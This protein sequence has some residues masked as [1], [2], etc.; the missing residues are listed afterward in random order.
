MP[1]APSSSRRSAA[2]RTTSTPTSSPARCSPSGYGPAGEPGGGRPRRREHLRVHRGGPRGVDR[3]DP[4]AG[5]A[6]A[7]GRPPRRHRLPGRALRRRAR[8]AIPEVD[9]VAGVRRAGRRCTTT[10][11]VVRTGDQAPSDGERR[12]EPRPAGAAAAAGEAP[13]AYVK[14]AEGCD[15]RAGSARS[16]ASVASSARGRSSVDPRRGR[17]P[18]CARDRA[19]RSGPRLLRPRTSATCAERD[20]G[21]ARRAGRAARWCRRVRLLYLY[22]SSLTD[23]LV[24]A[25]ARDRACRT[26]TSRCST[27]PARCCADAALRER[28]AL[29]RAHR[30][31]PRARAGRRVPVLVHP[32]LPRRDRGGP[33]RAARVPRGS[34][35]R[36]G[37]VLRVLRG[38]GDAGRRS[39]RAGRRRRS[40]SSGCASA[41]SCRTRS[42]R[43]GARDLVGTTRG[44]RRSAGRA[45]RS[46]REAPEIDG[47]VHVPASRLPG[48]LATGRRRPRAAGPDLDATGWRARDRWPEWPA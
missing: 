45:R 40:P 28:R 29:P 47:V 20:L 2:R 15:R 48:G 11:P 46:Y 23:E 30:A 12:P 6:P 39:R 1:G 3:D 33:R 35:A 32:R 26:S 4:R 22:P 21:R 7:R 17:G 44:A 13:W 36:L 41:R 37:R 16:R 14:V 31:D 5:A 27:P 9:L 10:R 24:E 38:G 42:R 34:G 43:A 18:R 8:A 19:R 25:I